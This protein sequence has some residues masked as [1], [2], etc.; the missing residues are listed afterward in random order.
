MEDLPCL[1]EGEGGEAAEEASSSSIVE[2]DV[3][4][5]EW[6]NGRTRPQIPARQVSWVGIVDIIRSEGRRVVRLAT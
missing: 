5:A 6:Q 4:C 2:L 1:E 3:K